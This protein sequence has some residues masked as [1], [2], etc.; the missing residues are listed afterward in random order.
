MIARKITGMM[1]AWA[2]FT[3]WAIDS[4]QRVRWGWIAGSPGAGGVTGLA[5]PASDIGGA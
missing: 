3:A 2:W 5:A 1:T 4:S